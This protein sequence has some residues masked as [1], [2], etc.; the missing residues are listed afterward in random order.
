MKLPLFFFI[1]IIYCLN[2]YSQRICEYGEYDFVFNKI[3]GINKTKFSKIKFLNKNEK[4]PFYVYKYDSLARLIEAKFIGGGMLF[5]ERVKSSCYG[6]NNSYYEYNTKEKRPNKIKVTDNNVIHAPIF[7]YNTN[8]SIKQIKYNNLTIDYK[9]NTKNQI[10]SITKGQKVYNYFWNKN[11]QIEKIDIL[12]L[13]D[14]TKQE[15]TF[16]YNKEKLKKVSHTQT[17]QG[18][19]QINNIYT[20]KYKNNRVCRITKFKK[21]KVKNAS[22]STIYYDYNYNYND[23]LIITRKNSK[24]K[25]LNHYECYYQ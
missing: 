21:K 6:I 16:Y 22:K 13:K 14:K 20:Y 4:E 25:Y 18:F 9:H 8:G 5:N 17:R 11:A 1:T 19:L 2:C 23:K 12:F 15:I 24:K 7:I 3:K 10:K